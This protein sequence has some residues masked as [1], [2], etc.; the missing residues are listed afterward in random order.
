MTTS[1]DRKHFEALSCPAKVTWTNDI[2][3][4]FTSVDV[5]HMIHAR[6]IDLSKYDD[7][8]IYATT[9]YARVANGTMPPPGTIGPDGQLEKPWTPEMVNLFGCWIQQ[10]TPQ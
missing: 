6:N 7:T 8:M 2:K 5:A 3:K 4:L 9:I 10:G 1:Y